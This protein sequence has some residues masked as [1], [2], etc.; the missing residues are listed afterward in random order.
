MST[1]ALKKSLK[2]VGAELLPVFDG[3]HKLKS[4]TDFLPIVDEDY[5]ALCAS[6]DLDA[7]CWYALKDPKLGIGSGG[8]RAPPAKDF[9]FRADPAGMKDAVKKLCAWIDK[10]GGVDAICGFSQGGELAYLIAEGM[11]SL[12]TRDKLKFIATFGSED[13][14]LQRGKAPECVLPPHLR[15]FICYGDGD[16]DAV[17]DSQTAKK[18]LEAAGASMAVTYMVKGLDHHMPKEGDAA[19]KAM[20][21]HFA[22]AKL[23]VDVADEHKPKALASAAP[24]PAPSPSPA[25]APAPSPAP[26]PTPAASPAPKYPG[27][28]APKYPGAA[29]PKYP[30]SSPARAP[31]PAPSP[32]PAPAPSPAPSPAPAPAPAASPAPK[33]PG[34]AAPKYPGSAPKYPGAASPKYPGSSP[35]APKYPGSS[36]SP[37]TAGTASKKLSRASPPKLLFLHGNGGSAFLAENFQIPGLVE[38]IKG[39]NVHCMNGFC[40]LKEAQL[41][42]SAGLDDE[43][44]KMALNGDI[45]L[46][47]WYES[48]TK[49]DC[50]DPV[51]FGRPHTETQNMPIDNRQIPGAVQKVKQHIIDA[52]GYD[53]IVAFSQGFTVALALAEELEAINQKCPKKVTFIAGF[54]ATMTNYVSR[55]HFGIK[56]AFTVPKPVAQTPLGPLKVF[57]C[58]GSRDE[59][60][61][62]ERVQKLSEMWS[63]AGA[64]VATHIWEGQHRLPPPGDKAYAALD[65]FV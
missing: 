35:A 53:G 40:K 46:F 45:E 5:R 17:V 55:S 18:T 50:V 59:H 39:A 33:Y 44:R 20:L 34:G 41:R 2:Q 64:A 22:D 63:T 15:F 27:G 21:N 19:Y 65:A 38:G 58:G 52:G 32:A 1:A 42:T 8:S 60:S 31:A 4:P 24:S 29:A 51:S 49:N 7:F 12:A 3:Y 36:P 26:A 54:G 56:E 14:Y 48:E 11:A 30:G 43:M 10:K 25:P 23:G 9:G 6:G 61:G 13:V 16:D 28:G 57:I 37:A 47:S 62:R